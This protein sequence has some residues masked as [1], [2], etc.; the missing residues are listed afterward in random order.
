MSLINTR[1]Q[2][3]RAGSRLDKNENR[4]SRYGALDA[5][6]SM[7]E[8]GAG[9]LTPEIKEKALNSIGSVLET[10][11]ID[12]RG[13]DISIGNTRT[14]TI[15]GTENTSQMLA[16]TFAT[17]SHGFTVVPALFK[18]NEI[19]MQH[20]FETKLN[21]FI[22]KLAATLD[23][24]AVAALAAA[25]TQVIADD[26]NYTVVGNSIQCPWKN[27][28]N[29]IGDIDPMMAA[30][31]FF[32]DIHVIGNAGIESIIRKLAEKGLYNEV[33]KTLEYS[34]KILHFTT[35]IANAEGKF[36]TA[37]AVC[38]GNLGLLFRQERDAMMNTRSRDGHEWGV[39]NLPLIGI[40]VGTYFYDT[41]EDANAIAGA[42][43]ADLTRTVVEHYGFSVDIAFVVAYNSDPTT[44]ASPIMKMEIASEAASDS[45]NVVIAN[46]TDNPVITQEVAGS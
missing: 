8:D 35:R 19:S 2:N 38:G 34:D 29:L 27:R 7:S 12:Y 45:L 22:Y 17:Y 11:V 24:A 9:I 21:A 10:P 32:N 14:V 33:N 16:I 30:N 4:P 36:A 1:I 15:T 42:A 31:D 43:T 46:T 13:G 23:T 40:P 44:L 20:D 26:L 28:E 6:I 39:E 37:Y 3:I 18:N 5:F 41:V 25:K